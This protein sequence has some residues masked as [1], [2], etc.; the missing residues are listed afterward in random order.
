VS[1]RYLTDT[2]IYVSAAN[3]PDFREQFE[4]FLGD[5]GP[6]EVSAVVVSEVLIGIADATRHSAAVRAL[7]AGSELLTPESSDWLQAGAAVAQLGGTAVTKSRSFWN[8]ALLA[9]QCARLDVVL[10]TR[11]TA[12]FRRLRR[13]ID[14]PT[15]EPFPSHHARWRYRSYAPAP[16]RK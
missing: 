14:V 5:R 1:P 2:N 6:L 8:D 3:D 12:H 10:V 7:T 9:A 13:F 15:A 4:R 11:N 16:A